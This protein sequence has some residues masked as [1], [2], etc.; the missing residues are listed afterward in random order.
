MNSD[1]TTDICDTDFRI[2]QRTL[3]NP[4][5]ITNMDIFVI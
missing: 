2:L 4:T 1:A 5:Y 3:S